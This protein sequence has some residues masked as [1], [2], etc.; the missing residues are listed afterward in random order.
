MI[1]YVMTLPLSQEEISSGKRQFEATCVICH[2]AGNKD[3]NMDF[4][5]FSDISNLSLANIENII[6]E[7]LG[8]DMPGLAIN[9]ISLRY[10]LLHGTQEF[11]DLLM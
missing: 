11:W 3:G 7:G 1:A 6:S 5:S 10:R 4:K 8:E 2:A 9:T